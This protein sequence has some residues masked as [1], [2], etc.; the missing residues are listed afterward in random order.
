MAR[1]VVHSREEAVLV[2]KRLNRQ[3]CLPAVKFFIH[4]EIEITAPSESWQKAGYMK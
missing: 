4:E 3:G 1:M 2:V